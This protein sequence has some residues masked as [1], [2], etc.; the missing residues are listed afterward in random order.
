MDAAR[1][2][3]VDIDVQ[4]EAEGSLLKRDLPKYLCRD[5]PARRTRADVRKAGTVKDRSIRGIVQNQT[6]TPKKFWVHVGSIT[7]FK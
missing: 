5:I 4:A 2:A 6:M 3:R 7:R 1:A